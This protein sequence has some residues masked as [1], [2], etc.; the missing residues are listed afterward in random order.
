MHKRLFDPKDYIG[1]QV[2]VVGGGDSATEAAISIHEAGVDVRLSYRG[3]SLTRPKAENIQKAE[4]LLGER[5]L[6]ET[7]VAGISQHT[8]VLKTPKGE[9]E[10]PNEAVFVLI[11]REAPVD[12]FHRSG[13]S[14]SGHWHFGKLMSLLCTLA[15]V[16]FIYRWK[17]ENS[18]VADWFLEN[19]WFPNN[20][21]VFAWG[22][23]ELWVRILEPNIA[24]P[25]FYYE[26]LYTLVVLLFGLRRI[27][28][29][30]TPYIRR[31]TTALILIQAIPLFLMPYLVLP[32]PGE[33]GLFDD[34]I[35][36]WVADQLFP[37]DELSGTR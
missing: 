32:L 1:R 12:F 22:I 14:I 31:Q 34:G 5:I 21:E 37:M 19:G 30:D 9:Q 15:T 4:A 17:T 28:R 25:G 20:I 27:A 35:G 10:L 33:S 29:Y 13:I 26:L 36:R 3:K 6:Y 18:E 16:L 11:G 23:N 7:E 8:V 24:S 2:L